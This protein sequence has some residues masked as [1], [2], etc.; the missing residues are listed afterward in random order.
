M[1]V[2]PPFKKTWPCTIF[3]PTFLNL[4]ES[5]PGEVIQIYFSSLKKKKRGGHTSQSSTQRPNS[6][7]KWYYLSPSKNFR[8]AKDQISCL[9][10][11]RI[12]T[13]KIFQDDWS[14]VNNRQ[15][16]TDRHLLIPINEQVYKFSFV[17]AFSSWWFDH[18]SYDQTTLIRMHK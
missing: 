2:S 7:L 17:Y 3:P 1:P 6:H 15:S 14:Q 13:S 18:R 9:V 16:F 8:P 5:P 12:Y 10:L 4:S 11:S